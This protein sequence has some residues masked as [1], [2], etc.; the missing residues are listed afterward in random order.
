MVYGGY[1]ISMWAPELSIDIVLIL[2]DGK[3]WSSLFCQGNV[4]T[5]IVHH[6]DF[7]P[8][9]W[10]IS[11]GQ[12]IL[13]QLFMWRYFDVGGGPHGT[14]HV[15]ITVL[16]PNWSWLC[17]TATQLNLRFMEWFHSSRGCCILN[18]DVP[19]FDVGLSWTRLFQLN[20]LAFWLVK[21]HTSVIATLCILNAWIAFVCLNSLIL[22]DI[23]GYSWI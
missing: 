22:L 15:F 16:A 9:H 2:E 10:L 19:N 4:R 11:E 17:V 12:Y 8:L 1:K 18:C 7:C 13:F 14:W 20:P 3:R 23:A 21:Y 6:L 5:I